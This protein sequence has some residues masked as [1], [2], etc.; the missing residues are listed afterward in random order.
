MENIDDTRNYFIEQINSNDM[1]NKKYKKICKALNYIA[2]F[3]F[4]TV[5]VTVCFSISAFAS[6]AGISKG[7]VSPAVVLKICVIAARF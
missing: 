2:H 7:I 3:F 4:L 1:T 5:A 6:G